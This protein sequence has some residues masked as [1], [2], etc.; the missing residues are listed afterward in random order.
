MTYDFSFDKKTISLLLGG[1]AFV[2]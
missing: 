1:L 2:G